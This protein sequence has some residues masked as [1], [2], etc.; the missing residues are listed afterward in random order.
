MRVSAS[1]LAIIAF[2][3][4]A[5]CSRP[6]EKPVSP[7]IPDLSGTW[8]RY[9]ENWYGVDP[10]HPPLPGGAF[11][12]KQPYASQYQAL[13]KREAAADAAGRPLLNASAQCLPEGM[14]TIM[15]AIYPIQILQTPGQVTVLAEF[16]TQTRR[17]LLDTK[18]PAPDD[19]APTYNGTAVGHYEGDALVVETRGVRNDVRFYDLPHSQDMIIREQIRHSAPDR[20]VDEV[21]I[22]DPKTLN[23][24]YKFTFEYKKTDYKIQEYICEKNEIKVDPDGG[25]EVDLSNVANK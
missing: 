22:T 8:V 12:L 16:L 7:K 1:N 5:G 14:P 15:G 23:K 3:I 2:L 4:T 6:V 25:T 18:M 24:P 9:P 21:T 19:I 10:D 13:K 11:N 20:I 17:I